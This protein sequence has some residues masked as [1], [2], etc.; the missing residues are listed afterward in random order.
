[1]LFA[2]R[3]NLRPPEETVALWAQT[4]QKFDIGD[5]LE[6]AQILGEGSRWVP[7]LPE[8]T[9]AIR[10][11]R[12]DRI[13]RERT[14]LPAPRTPRSYYPFALFLRENPE[15]GEIV[16]SLDATAFAPDRGCGKNVITSTLADMLESEMTG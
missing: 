1:M 10:Q 7:V 12:D 9:D 2:Y 11:C 13:R 3:P 16:A 4:V 15:Q 8:F 14:A 6:A 5:A